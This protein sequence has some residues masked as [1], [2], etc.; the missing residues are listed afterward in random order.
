MSADIHRL[1]AEQGQNEE[2]ARLSAE[3]SVYLDAYLAPFRRWLD[4]DTVP[5]IRPVSRFQEG[6]ASSRCGS[7]PL[8]TA[9]SSLQNR[10]AL[11][12]AR[13]SSGS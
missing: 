7:A 11:W 13:S 9:S 10:L 2:T 1:M 3:R 4:R 8:S 5:E 12:M 6:R